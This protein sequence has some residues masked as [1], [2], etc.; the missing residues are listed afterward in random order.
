MVRRGWVRLGE[1][2][3]GI[4]AN[5]LPPTWES[6][7]GAY[8]RAWNA[9]KPPGWVPLDDDIAH[10]QGV[11]AAL[12]E[13]KRGSRFTTMTTNPPKDSQESAVEVARTVLSGA[14]QDSSMPLSICEILAQEVLSMQ[15]RIEE[16]EIERS[17]MITMARRG[18]DLTK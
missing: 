8:W 15:E 9:N 1:V 12:K 17:S 3:R 16:L 11:I 18:E 10:C 14:K 7:E 2:W 6:V 5:E 13:M 4:M